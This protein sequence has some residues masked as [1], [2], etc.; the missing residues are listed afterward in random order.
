MNPYT[1]SVCVCV[2]QTWEV[3]ILKWSNNLLNITVFVDMSVQEYICMV[4]LFQGS[5]ETPDFLLH[6]SSYIKTPLYCDKCCIPKWNSRISALQG[7]CQFEVYLVVI[8]SF[9][10]LN[11]LI[12]LPWS[13]IL[14]VKM[15]LC[16][17]TDLVD[18]LQN[19][20]QD[21]KAHCFRSICNSSAHV[22]NHHCDLLSF[23]DIITHT[24]V[25]AT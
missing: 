2:C 25:H 20:L 16:L 9:Q 10:G 15:L 22:A 12:F 11:L 21:I 6:H 23:W 13:I 17:S 4:L 24:L 18:F 14:K 7:D 5:W 3:I 19:I 1:I 8:I